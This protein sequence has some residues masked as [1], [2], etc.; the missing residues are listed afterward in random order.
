MKNRFCDQQPSP[1]VHPVQDTMYKRPNPVARR[2]CYSEPKRLH[3]DDLHK[4]LRPTTVRPRIES[5]W[6]PSTHYKFIASYMP[7]EAAEAYI[8][9]SE[10]WFAEHPPR[11]PPPPKLRE[12]VDPE[13]VTELIARYG[14]NVPISEYARVG[15]SEEA[16]AKI[17]A[18]RQWFIDH[19]AE[20]NAEIERRWPCSV[21]T[22]T[23]K[24]I[25]AVKKKM[26]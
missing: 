24:V 23:K 25:K 14:T 2:G 17:Q 13:A 22:K 5:E 6:T 15:Y 18:R 20:L 11:P 16:L 10:A 8:A 9:R 21:K 1:S 7:K 3:P 4:I 26:H 12:N 19:D